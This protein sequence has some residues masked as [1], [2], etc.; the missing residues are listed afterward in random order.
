MYDRVQD[1]ERNQNIV[2][3]ILNNLPSES[4]ITKIEY[5]GPFIVLYSRKPTTLLEN[6]EIIS[7]MVNSIKKRIVIRTDTSI[8]SPEDSVRQIIHSST[9][10]P[11]T[12]S[13]I[14][15]DPALGEATIFV[16]DFRT[17]TELSQLEIQLVEK[18][19]WKLIYRYVPSDLKL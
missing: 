10:Y 17:L 3:A 15:F 4:E 1:E 5:E 16:N 8:R 18:T 2:A 9:S 19:G 14:F 7:K 6:Q 13:E 12:I 11:N